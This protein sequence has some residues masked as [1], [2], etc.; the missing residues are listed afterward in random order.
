MLET[1]FSDRGLA[2]R[3]RLLEDE[4]RPRPRKRTPRTGTYSH[5]ADEARSIL[6]PA[7]GPNNALS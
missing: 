2:P 4:Q 1:E 7:R 6:I 3:I 5:T